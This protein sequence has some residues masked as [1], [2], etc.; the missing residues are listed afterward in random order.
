MICWLPGCKAFADE[1]KDLE[2]ITIEGKVYN[3]KF[4]LGGDLAL[5]CGTDAANSIHTCVWCK[6]PKEI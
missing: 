5:A 6:C 1:A 2:A 3:I 4:F